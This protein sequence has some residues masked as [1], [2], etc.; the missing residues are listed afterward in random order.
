M[1]K[2]ISLC[3]LFAKLC[4]CRILCSFFSGQ[5]VNCSQRSLAM[6]LSKLTSGAPKPET[7]PEEVLSM[8]PRSATN[9]GPPYFSLVPY[10][11]RATC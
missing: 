2:K 1:H 4:C 3:K 10:L 6:L 9:D 7:R 11:E 5:V 8:G